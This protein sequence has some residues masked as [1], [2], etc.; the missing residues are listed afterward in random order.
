[1]SD[2][3]STDFHEDWADE[4]YKAGLAKLAREEKAARD[5]Y[6]A[7]L[8]FRE[9]RLREDEGR[10]FDLPRLRA[11]IHFPGANVSARDGSFRHGHTVVELV[12]E[13]GNPVGR[14][15]NIQEA[16]VAA[17]DTSFMSAEITIANVDV[18]FRDKKE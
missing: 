18:E 15:N 5:K 8:E 2:K 14:L 7:E 12:D 13:D 10:L 16:R 6:R 1:M 9:G 4:G 3:P 17:S 11:V